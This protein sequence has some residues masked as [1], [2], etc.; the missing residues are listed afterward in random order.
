MVLLQVGQ[1]LASM[2]IVKLNQFFSS[3]CRSGLNSDLHDDFKKKSYEYNQ[4]G[5]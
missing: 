4:T 2:H 3:R 5:T 1:G